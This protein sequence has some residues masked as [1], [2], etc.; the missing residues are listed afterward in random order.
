MASMSYCRFENTAGDLWDCVEDLNKG[1]VLNQ[2]EE[3]CRHELLKAA[4]AY[5]EAYENYVPRPEDDDD[6]EWDV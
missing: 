2:Y 1:K 4:K 5:I 3:P 6:E